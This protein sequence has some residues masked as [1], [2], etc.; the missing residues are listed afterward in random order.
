MTNT[1][2]NGEDAPV[3]FSD[4]SVIVRKGG[5]SFKVHRSLIESLSHNFFDSDGIV[6][7]SAEDSKDISVYA[8]T[9]NNIDVKHLKSIFT[10]LYHRIHLSADAPFDHVLRLYISTAPD[11]ANM[12]SVH[13]LAAKY[14]NEILNINPL[15]VDFTDIKEIQAALNC[16]RAF[17]HPELQTSL[18]K[19]LYYAYMISDNVIYP[20]QDLPPPTPVDGPLLYRLSLTDAHITTH[21]M[22]SITDFFS[23]TIFQPACGSHMA[24]TDIFAKHW[25]ALAADPV[26]EDGGLCD[27]FRTLNR[28]STIAWVDEKVLSVCDECL[29]NVRE[30][31]EEEAIV[32]WGKIGEWIEEAKSSSKELPSS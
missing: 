12:P 13:E 29:K 32:I 20:G 28:L 23:P 21:L 2:T 26:L 6:K 31:W 22:T 18:E 8:V 27:T 24:C 25:V 14:L 16:S 1:S 15:N 3:W 9:S 5:T 19:A 4:G 17:E 10:H 11:Y 7:M 30:E